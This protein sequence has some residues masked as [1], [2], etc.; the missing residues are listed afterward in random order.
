MHTGQSHTEVFI[1]KYYFIKKKKNATKS[2]T[3]NYSNSWNKTEDTLLTSN[4]INQT[5][6]S[7]PV[8][9]HL[10][11]NRHSSIS[12]F[13]MWKWFQQHLKHLTE[14]SY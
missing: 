14:K 6:E 9:E 5:K 1:I 7:S 13:Q 12:F 11:R 2:K 8:T 10:V 4:F 3:E